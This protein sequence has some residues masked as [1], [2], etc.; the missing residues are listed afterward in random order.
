MIIDCL[1][2]DDFSP[3]PDDCT[4]FYRC[5]HGYQFTFQC[6]PGTGFERRLKVCNYID[7]IPECDDEEGSDSG[8]NSTTGSSNSTLTT[9]GDATTASATTTEATTAT[10]TEATTTT[11]TTTE[12]TTTVSTTTT[13]TTPDVTGK[14][15]F[16]FI[17]QLIYKA[18]FLDLDPTLC[19]KLTPDEKNIFCAS[20][21]FRQYYPKCCN[22]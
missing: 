3:D 9:T 20:S 19:T 14:N 4:I 17:H 15:F 7:S 13:N 1:D 10:T 12:T 11:A 5:S 2:S 21:T 16:K 8:K 6:G 22:S 18:Y